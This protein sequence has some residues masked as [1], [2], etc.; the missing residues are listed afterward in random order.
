MLRYC[1]VKE[2]KNSSSDAG[3]V[4]FSF[5]Q[6][7]NVRDTW[8][9]F[10]DRPN[11]EVK[12]TCKVCSAHFSPHLIT[13]NHHLRPGSLPPGSLPIASSSHQ[14]CKTGIYTG[15]LPP[16]PRTPKIILTHKNIYIYIYINTFF[17]SEAPL[18]ETLSVCLSVCRSVGYPTNNLQLTLFHRV[19]WPLL[20][21]IYV[22]LNINAQFNPPSL[23]SLPS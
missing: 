7:K 21:T 8:V 9:S 6:D 16:I 17:R 5:P 15:D 3:I 12:K 1:S 10:I 23:P 4:F 14:T 22:D 18:Q 19:I 11:W 13:G 20:R 2:C